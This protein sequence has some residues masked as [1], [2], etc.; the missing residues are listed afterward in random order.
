MLEIPLEAYQ[1]QSFMVTLKEQDCSLALYQRNSRLYL[2]LSVDG[3]L[4]RQGAVCLPQVGILG[5]VRGFAGELF[6]VD[7]R[8]QPEK[9]QPPQW[10]GLG[11]RWKLYYL[12]PEEV[13]TLRENAALEALHG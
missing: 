5:N 4:V 13:Q 8:T 3:A 12:L 7:Q 2:D 10:E 9:Q 6:M 1:N 11:T